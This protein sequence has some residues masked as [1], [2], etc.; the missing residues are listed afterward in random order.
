[1]VSFH[2]NGWKNI[3]RFERFEIGIKLP[4]EIDRK[5]DSF[6]I[7]EDGINPY[8]FNKIRIDAIFSKS[9]TRHYK[10]EGFYYRQIIIDS[11]KNTFTQSKSDF[12]F[13]VRFAPPEIGD[14]TFLLS[15]NVEGNV[16]ATFS[17]S[18]QVVES[19]KR[20]FLSLGPYSHVMDAR[21]NTFFA[22]GQAIPFC[23]Y[24]N[25]SINPDD[26]TRQRRYIN[27]LADNSGN[28]FRIR[29]DPWSN[30]LELEEVG[31]YGSARTPKE[32]FER[33]WHAFELDET[34]RLAEEKDMY[35]FITL[36][37][38]YHFK[39]DGSFSLGWQVNPY[40][41]IEKISTDFFDVSNGHSLPFYKN[42]LRYFMAR[43]G[44]C[45]N[46]GVI[47]LLNETDQ[48]E[49]YG[50]SS[51]VRSNVN[52]W[53]KTI[54]E[55]LKD[56]QFYPRPLLTNGYA[57]GPTKPDK[58]AT[59]SVFDILSTNHYSNS[60]RTIKR[61]HDDLPRHASSMHDLKKP[62]IFGEIGAGVCSAPNTG[63]E[64]WFSDAE[65]H[66]GIW[67]T[68]MYSRAIGNGLYWWDWEQESHLQRENKNIQG[69]N[70]RLNFRALS[71][72]FTQAPP[73]LGT[74]E[75]SSTWDCNLKSASELKK[76]KTEWIAN[77]NKEGTRGFGWVH[78]S[79]Y[80]WINDSLGLTSRN[81]PDC[82]NG[83]ME[84]FYD[85]EC[86]KVRE[87][88]VRVLNE[89]KGPYNFT[90]HKEEITLQGYKRFQNYKIEIWSCYGEGGLRDTMLVKSNAKGKI[91]FRHEVGKFPGD[92]N[93][94]DPDF[95]FK[96]YLSD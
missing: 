13:R 81:C 5:V 16:L 24:P 3:G 34:F 56:V 80:F 55:Y 33:Q 18:L 39:S 51:E 12:P 70:H 44:Y 58:G 29:L 61:R 68:S 49:N 50:A 85:S 7:G 48:L 46:I 94:G 35:M 42:K 15:L 26:F 88:D 75:F 36:L 4:P 19:K 89:P 96:V 57:V 30:E 83:G 92:P 41:A 43:Y 1:M 63:H 74:E 21:R 67:S 25:S 95:A 38:D 93:S 32:N 78:N 62:F 47:G 65:F 69:I 73:P 52:E 8:D 6:L 28:F 87:S 54:G 77:V 64:D 72:F 17:G 31:V 60:R 71:T 76:R 20:G 53:L 66:N 82:Q 9:E 40:R 10:R 84:A 14:Y 37:G 27:E 11:I 59:N 22:M 79:D 45:S 90:A 86:Y 91:K 23:E 2:K